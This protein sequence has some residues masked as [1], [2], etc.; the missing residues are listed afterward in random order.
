LLLEYPQLNYTLN[1]TGSM[2]LILSPESIKHS[3]VFR[4]VEYDRNSSVGAQVLSAFQFFENPKNF[5]HFN[6]KGI[7]QVIRQRKNWT[8]EEEDW[9]SA[10][11]SE[12]PEFFSKSFFR[13]IVCTN[14]DYIRDY[15]TQIQNKGHLIET[16]D[17][18]T[19]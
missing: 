16:F 2:K 18:L 4:T 17:C 7:K 19:R 15:Y 13:T 6:R 3:P 14:M 11:N 10:E 5:A 9:R 12:K 1:V 8:Q